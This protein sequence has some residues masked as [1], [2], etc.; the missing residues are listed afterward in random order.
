MEYAIQVE[1]VSKIYK[2][3][4]NQQDRIKEAFSLRNKQYHTDF[5]ALSNIDFSVKKGETL[6]IIGKNGAGKS[7]LLKLITGVTTPTEGSIRVNGEVSALL[8]LGTGFNPEFNGYE[9]IYLNGVMRGFSKD[10][11]DAKLDEI[12]SF[13]DIGEYIS[14]PVKT[15]SSGMFA[16]LAFA[17]MISFRPEILI[18]DEALSVGDNFFQQKCNT[19][20]K[21]KM[22]G[23]TKILVTH[24]MNSVA[25]MA[26][27]AILLDRGQMVDDGEP[28]RIIEKYLKMMHTTVFSEGKEIKKEMKKDIASNLSDDNDWIVVDSSKT[29]GAGDAAITACSVLINGGKGDVVKR[30]DILS[31]YFKIQFYKA[32]SHVIIGYIIKDKYGNSIAGENSIG[33][34]ITL[35]PGEEGKEYTYC[36]KIQWPEIQEGDYFITLGIGNGTDQMIH[37]IEC[38]AHNVIHLQSIALV[39]MHG[40]INNPIREINRNES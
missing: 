29:G 5:S 24:D 34:K 1:H 21:E 35:E 27:R 25:N 3:Y 11:M 39:P 40:I 20:M 22:A 37:T 16:R 14:Q 32:L 10:E 15:Y 8:E 30:G 2:L 19:Y 33:S 6:A 13:A 9:N 17:V 38:W 23:V 18:V 26:D 36:V 31:F 4:K 28:L 12:I 7:T